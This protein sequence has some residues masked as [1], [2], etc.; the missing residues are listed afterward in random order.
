MAA[1]EEAGAVAFGPV[2]VN[3]VPPGT[4]GWIGTDL[5]RLFQSN[6]ASAGYMESLTNRRCHGLVASAQT[7]TRILVH[8]ND[9][10]M[11]VVGSGGA[12]GSRVFITL[13]PR[14]TMDRHY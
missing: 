3:A 2:D 1:A 12:V 4:D 5:G 8:P 13:R 14:R 9:R 10:F 6:A 7:I 11:V